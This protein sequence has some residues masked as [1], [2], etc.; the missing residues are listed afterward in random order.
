MYEVLKCK[1]SRGL[2]DD[3]L[4]YRAYRDRCFEEGA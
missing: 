3:L 1:E 4:N 2:T